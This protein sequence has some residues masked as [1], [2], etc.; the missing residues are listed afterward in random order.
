M[1]LMSDGFEQVSIGAVG[2]VEGSRECGSGYL[3]L[4]ALGGPWE[5]GNHIDRLFS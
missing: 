3:D 5:L 2:D 1:S 4:S